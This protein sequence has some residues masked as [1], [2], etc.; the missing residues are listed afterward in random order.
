MPPP[1]V[2]KVPRAGA[3]AEGPG[4][5]SLPSRSLSRRPDYRGGAL[6]LGPVCPRPVPTGQ[7]QMLTALAARPF[8]GVLL[9]HSGHGD[10]PARP[11][12]E[13]PHSWHPQ[14][15][16]VGVVVQGAHLLAGLQQVQEARGRGPSR[17]LHLGIS[18]GLGVRVNVQGALVRGVVARLWGQGASQD[19]AAPRDMKKF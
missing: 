7:Q 8:L 9:W 3:A 14:D 19:R 13:H 11:M 15:L 10:T 17:L 18:G 1:T 4:P 5:H 6:V 16:P 12:G 2:V